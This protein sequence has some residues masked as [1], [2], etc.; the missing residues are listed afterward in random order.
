MI[1]TLALRLAAVSTAA[2][3]LAACNQQQKAAAPADYHIYVS[4]EISGDLTVIDGASQTVVANVKLGKRP[5]GVK[6]SPDG[7][8]VYVALSGS[9]IAPPGTDEDKLPPP[10]KS[11]DGIGVLN[12]AT[13]Q[14]MKVLKNVEDPEQILVSPDGST[15]YSA[16]QDAQKI[17]AIDSQSGAVKQ[18][19][20]AGKEPEG[21][22]ITPDGKQIYVSSEEGGQVS[23]FSLPDLK[24]LGKFKVG[25][26][27]RGIAFSPDGTKAYVTGEADASLAEIDTAKMAVTRKVMV[28]GAGAK[29]MGVAVSPDGGRIFVAMGRGGE[30]AAFD[31]QSLNS[32]GELSVGARPWGVA[33]SPDG[34]LVYTANGPSGD[35]GVVDA[36]T[37]QLVRKIK[38]DDRPWGVAVGP[39]PGQ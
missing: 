37:M 3:A 2:L 15:I 30:L 11:A 25:D 10:D 29:P 26:R 8:F 9:P 28:P 27:P 39:V 20:D 5:R 12:A 17:L 13:L 22:G 14:L 38:A 32:V 24:P 33:I 6:V 36:K 31:A 35:V 21:L 1:S 7:R 4:N 16:S 18:T 19:G 23:V 34:A